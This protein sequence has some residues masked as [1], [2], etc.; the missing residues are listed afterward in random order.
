METHC[1]PVRATQ[2]QRKDRTDFGR[3]SS[4]STA[5]PHY[6]VAVLNGKAYRLRIEYKQASNQP[7]GSTATPGTWMTIH[8]KTSAPTSPKYLS[9]PTVAPASDFGVP[10]PLLSSLVLFRKMKSRKPV[11]H[12]SFSCHLAS[13]TVNTGHTAVVGVLKLC[14]RRIATSKA[15]MRVTGSLW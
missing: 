3:S 8:P 9:Q 15:I 1:R 11:R 12:R 14:F 10:A 5:L 2:R 4:A 6:R 13:L 7:K